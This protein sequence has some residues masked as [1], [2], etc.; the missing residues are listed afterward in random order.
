MRARR[1]NEL[2]GAVGGCNSRTLRDRLK[3][4]EELGVIERHVVPE[5]PI[6]VEYELTDKGHQLG[7]AI[8]R[9]ETWARQHMTVPVS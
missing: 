8:A 2:A 5:P 1:F 3:L 6:G 4:L 7:E 9:V